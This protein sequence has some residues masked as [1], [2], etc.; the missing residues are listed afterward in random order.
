MCRRISYKIKYFGQLTSFHRCLISMAFCY[1]HG[2]GVEV[3]S[4]SIT[5]LNQFFAQTNILENTLIIN[6]VI[7]LAID[8]HELITYIY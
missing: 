6:L 7:F 4:V 2:V 1:P 5:I 3:L 8:N